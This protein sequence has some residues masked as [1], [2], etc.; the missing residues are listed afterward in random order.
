MKLL[1]LL[2]PNVRKWIAAAGTGVLAGILSFWHENPTHF[3]TW[4]DLAG[5]IITGMGLT[6]GF[7]KVSLDV[8]AVSKPPAK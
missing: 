3:T 1:A 5:H 6:M 8:D 7:L 2:T 4:Y